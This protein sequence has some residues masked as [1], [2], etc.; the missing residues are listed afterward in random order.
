MTQRASV[1]EL[2]RLLAERRNTATATVEIKIMAGN[3]VAPSVTVTPDTTAEEIDRMTDLALRAFTA[4]LAETTA[5]QVAKISDKLRDSVRT[6]E[7]Q[8][9]RTGPRRTK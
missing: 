5:T 6:I 8:K 1:S 9:K 7:D 3:V 4:I 2:A